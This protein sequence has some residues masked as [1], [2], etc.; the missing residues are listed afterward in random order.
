M[1][2]VLICLYGHWLHVLHMSLFPLSR[3]AASCQVGE[4]S[5]SSSVIL[6]W[7][8]MIISFLFWQRGWLCVMW[9]CQIEIINTCG[10]AWTCCHKQN[11]RR[12]VTFATSWGRSKGIHWW[13]LGGSWLSTS[14]LRWR[15]MIW[16]RCS[17]SSSRL[18]AP[19]VRQNHSLQCQLRL[20][21]IQWEVKLCLLMHVFCFY[22]HL[23][24][25]GKHTYLQYCLEGIVKH[26]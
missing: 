11:A 25:R 5:D 22:T 18:G 17:C 21:E 20:W 8:L 1:I 4:S 24:C 26:I 9:I 14:A 7:C 6:Q 23:N 12:S 13:I 15:I 19:Q 2:K 10:H 3:E 16:F